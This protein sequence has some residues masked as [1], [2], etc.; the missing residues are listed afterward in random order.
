MATFRVSTSTDLAR[1]TQQVSI[2]G[3]VRSD[4]FCPGVSFGV[5]AQGSTCSLMLPGLTWDQKKNLRGQFVVV[6]VSYEGQPLE[7][8]FNGY[9]NNIQGN[10]SS[11]YV[12][13]QCVSLLGLSGNVYIGQNRGETTGYNVIYPRKVGTRE[14]GWGVKDILGDFFSANAPTWKGGGGGIPADW[15]S[16]LSLG[17][18]S[19]LNSVYNQIPLGDISFKQGTLKSALEQ[20]LGMV[21]TISLREN[22]K[23]NSTELDF[24]EVAPPN[25][26]TK[27][28]SVALPGEDVTGKNVLSISQDQGAEDVKTRFVGLGDDRKYIISISSSLV[29]DWSS[30]LDA[31]VL[32]NPEG[33]KRSPSSGGARGDFQEAKTQVFRKYNLPDSIKALVID[34]DILGT[35]IQI[36]KM[37]STP[38]A[39]QAGGWFFTD[40]TEP[41]L[42]EGTQLDLENGTFTLKE[43]AI[44]GASSVVNTAGDFVTVNTEA[45]V[46]I[47]LVVNNGRLF[48]DTGVV[49][50]GMVFD[51]IDVSGLTEVIEN[52]SFRYMK[53]TNTGYPVDGVTYD[54]WLQDGGIWTQHT[55]GTVLEDD[56]GNLQLFVHIALKEKNAIQNI[57]DVQ[58]PYWTSAFKLGDSIQVSGQEDY[59][60]VTHQIMSLSY[61]L[62]NDHSTSFSTDTQVPMVANTILGG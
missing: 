58:T 22:F 8:V 57:Y 35:P 54:C 6:K 38:V 23:A 49:P 36:W 53:I 27:R 13:C 25:A 10:S 56:G 21:G 37:G 4:A 55:T 43:P 46:G 61:D 16:R 20:L 59:E 33:G 41:T 62:T 28:V 40:D 44:K 18:L 39:T 12:N 47:T 2:G 52:R 29:K 5:G 31:S 60:S 11:N 24:F 51:G 26:P 45:Q 48:T 1:L 34:K 42:L 9:I 15:R 17:S 50:N 32:N 14:T 3:M 30:S 19:V 7:V